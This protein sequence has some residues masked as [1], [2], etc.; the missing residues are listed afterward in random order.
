MSCNYTIYHEP[1]LISVFETTLSVQQ[2]IL[3]VFNVVIQTPSTIISLVRYPFDFI[4]FHQKIRTHYPRSTKI[5]FPALSTPVTHNNM[6]RLHRRRSIKNLLSFSK[7]SNADKIEKYLQRCFDHPIV[8]ISSLLRD[9]LSVQRDE[10]KL[11]P[12]QQQQQQQ[13]QSTLVTTQ[14]ITATGSIN[15]TLSRTSISEKSS[16]QHHIIASTPPPVPSLILQ[17]SPPSIQDYDLLK[18]LGKGCMGKV[19]LVRSKLNKRLYALKAIQ[20]D[21]VIQQKEVTHTQAERDILVK[22]RQEPFLVR[23]QCAFQ[24][25]GQLFLVLDYYSGGDI[26]TQM[27]KF[28]TFS[29]G[30]TLFYAAE[31]VHGLST[32]HKHGI[33]YRDLKP[34]NVL[35]GRDGHIVL[36]D[37]G[38]SKVFDVDTDMPITRTFC[39]TAEYLAPEVLTD[40][41]YTFVVDY[42]SLGTLLYEMLAGVTPFW[43]ETHVEMYRR[44]LDDPLEFPPHFDIITCDFLAGLLERDPCERLGWD[45]V[46]SIQTHPYFS[47]L[48]WDDVANLALTPPYIPE[49]V[50]ETDLSHF[51][52]AFINMSPRISQLSQNNS[53]E[54]YFFDGDN[55]EQDPFAASFS[56]DPER[57]IVPTSEEQEH[58]PRLLRQKLQRTRAQQKK[59]G[60]DRFSTSSSLL[61][62]SPGEVIRHTDT[63]PSFL[64]QQRYSRKRHSAALSAQHMDYLLSTANNNSS[65]PTTHTKDYYQ[66]H[67][68]QNQQQPIVAEISSL[69]SSMTMSSVPDDEVHVENDSDNTSSDDR[70]LCTQQQQRHP[71]HHNE[72]NISSLTAASTSNNSHRQYHQQN[73][74][75]H[76]PY[77]RPH[78]PVPGQVR[79]NISLDSSNSNSNSTSTTPMTSQRHSM[80]LSDNLHDNH[81]NPTHE[82]Q[83]QQQQQQ[84]QQHSYV[85]MV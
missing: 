18:V 35:I 11:L 76:S 68:N 75:D 23:L 83:Q 41:P 67:N 54:E 31:I 43:A 47:H 57:D 36:T 26:A 2:E 61:S 16:Y 20:K 51:D 15:T 19:I 24:T 45:G 60:K 70:I 39:G 69:C 25:P 5:P 22:L 74:G 17:N 10:D 66:H 80:C 28:T 65:T 42:W 73:R 30:R 78:C 52:E 53:K 50:S 1:R 37:F 4:E 63:M 14:P 44:V 27:S 55:N 81:N 48:D 12:C 7:K 21:H 3:S 71:H 85:S 6:N 46:T 84:Q 40:E 82:W 8:S 33:I 58:P 79:P 56:F 13:Q 59:S 9:F 72:E 29:E 62:F 49:L 34:E 77:T 38:L 64:Q 32:L